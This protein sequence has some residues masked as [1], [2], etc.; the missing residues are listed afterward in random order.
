VLAVAVA[1]V[2][3]GRRRGGTGATSAGAVLLSSGRA[4]HLLLGSSD[5]H[6]GSSLLILNDDDDDAGPCNHSV[7][8]ALHRPIMVK[9]LNVDVV[10]PSKTANRSGV[11]HRRF[12][13]IS[14]FT[15]RGSRVMSVT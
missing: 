8:C 10:G 11:S 7:L 14:S 2:V 3:V 15:L 5:G 6:G 12:S 9:C 13:L 4:R 1:V